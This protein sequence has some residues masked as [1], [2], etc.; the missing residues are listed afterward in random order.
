MTVLYEDEDRPPPVVIH[1]PHAST[2]IPDAC[3]YFAALLLGAFRGLSKD[4]LLDPAFG[5]RNGFWR[6]HPLAPNVAVVAAGHWRRENPPDIKG[7]SGY[8]IDTLTA[9][10]WAFH[11]LHDFRHGALAAVNLC[12]DADT[13][14]A[15]YGQLAGA[16]YGLSGIP[17]EW[18]AVLPDGD[19][20]ADVARRLFP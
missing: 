3:R 14:G 18:R 11:H 8:V 4:E 19:Q 9:A 13:T 5:D 17:E 2:E 12:G 6:D 10:L 16:H 20:I 1:V 7:G 15:V